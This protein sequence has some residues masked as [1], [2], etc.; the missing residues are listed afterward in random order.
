M[1]QTEHNR[2][3][4]FRQ[5][6]KEV[7]GS[8]EYLL[9]GIDIGKE[10]H[11][12]FFG[13]ATGKTLLR[14]LIF[15]NSREGFEK[16]LIQVEALKVI[17]GLRQVV[18][19]MEP[20]ANY[21]KPLGEYLIRR[22]KEV[23]LVSGLAVVKNRELMDN[24]WDKHD[25]KDAANIADLV[26]QGKC[27]F[28]EYPSLALRELRDLLSLKRRLKKQEHGYRVRIRNH[29]LAQ[30]FPEM[31]SEYEQSKVGSLGVVKW[32]LSP[33]K[34]A[35]MEYNEFVKLVSRGRV[36]GVQERRLRRIWEKAGESIGCEAGETVGFG[37]SL[38]V[39]GL[40]QVREML[41]EIEAKV[42][43]VCKGFPEYECLLSIPGYGQDV[44]SK[45]LGAIGDPFRFNNR[46]QVLKL[47]G[48]DL[49]AERSGKA[50]EGR[51]PVISKRGK[52]D[53]RYALYQA[54]LVASVKDRDVMVYYTRLLRG[55]ERE[56]GIHN[57]MRV[58]LAAKLL[59]IAWTLM[60]KKERYDPAYLSRE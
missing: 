6:R 16:L 4:R 60:K 37:A 9:V 35:E 42:G 33:V 10:N 7:R 40:R 19:G 29:L 57:K 47:S 59:V 21:H 38:M 58:K 43:E 8:Q 48:Y 56:K 36:G 20:T 3:E 34:I 17:H 24:R 23:V 32:C 14:R 30:Y 11:H 18:Y 46:A 25:S 13:T 50:S 54:A 22:G 31:D 53:L 39:D 55:R 5:F 52:S 26:S 12:A 27:L 51:V 15:D 1:D 2:V 28:Y 41:K 45:V 44:S 49:S